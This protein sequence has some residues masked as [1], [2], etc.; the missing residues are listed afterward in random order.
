MLNIEK[1][2]SLSELKNIFL[3]ER[4]VR[5]HGVRSIEFV[6]SINEKEVGFLSYEDWQDRSQGFIQEVFVLPNFRRNGVAQ[7][8][9]KHAENHAN[10]LNCTSVKLKP[11]ALNQDPEIR[12]LISWYL[13]NGY[14]RSFS[15]PELMEKFLVKPRT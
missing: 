8:L 9:L 12:S 5:M 13:R 11:Y 10:R 1:I 3:H 7:S 14:I 4:A 6:A 2:S 15:E